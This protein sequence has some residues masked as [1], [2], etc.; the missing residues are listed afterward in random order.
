MTI[1]RNDAGTTCNRAALAR[2]HGVALACGLM[3]IAVLAA[4]CGI[5]SERKAPAEIKVQQIAREKT[6][7][8]RDLQQAKAENQQLA[9][10]I[11]ALS[12]FPEDKPLNPYRLKRVKITRYTNFYDKDNDGKR[13]KLIVYIEP[14]DLDGDAVKAAGTVN[15]QLWNLNNLNGQALLGQWQ[16]D[17]N[18]LRKLWYD[19]L[20][21]ANYRLIFDA[22]PELDVL[23]EPL[24]VKVT[25]TDYLT[26]EIFRDQYAIDPRTNQ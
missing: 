12:V 5:G 24:T 2:G 7:L 13:E 18:D 6:E 10:Q 14:I 23:A 22:P 11:K 16:V 25:F 26:G 3:L 8:M 21:S 17:P 9:E 1:T 20:V 15:V 19:T 4:G